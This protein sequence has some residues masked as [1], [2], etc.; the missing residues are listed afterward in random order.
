MC[1]LFPRDESVV[2]VKAV[3]QTGNN[4]S[5]G[6]FMFIH[7]LAQMKH[8]IYEPGNL[9]IAHCTVRLVYAMIIRV[10]KVCTRS[11]EKPT[12]NAKRGNLC[13]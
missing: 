11:E 10:G 1:R 7:R 6:V 8:F 12:Q 2:T 4:N 5:M 9:A 13:T 3:G